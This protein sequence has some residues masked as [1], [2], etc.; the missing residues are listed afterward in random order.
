[1]R[2]MGRG[3]ALPC[4]YEEIMCRKHY[5]NW[6]EA[7]VSS[8]E[9]EVSSSEHQV[10]CYEAE[11]S[12]SEHQVSCSEHQVTSSEAENLNISKTYA[13]IIE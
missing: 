2:Q 13:R 11:V 1:M 8:S 9:A 12:C 3:T 5:L 4:P 7:E 10:S 6:Y